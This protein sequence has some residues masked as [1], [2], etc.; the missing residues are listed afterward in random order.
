MTISGQGALYQ[1]VGPGS[2][3]VELA[4]ASRFAFVG[5][6]SVAL[7]I[8]AVVAVA[9][10]I[11]CFGAQVLYERYAEGEWRVRKA[12]K[13]TSFLIGGLVVFAAAATVVAYAVWLI[14]RNR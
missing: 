4:A 8:A 10:W 1:I 13:S 11:I 3:P 6:L 5:E 12:V 9:L 7:L 2:P 14:L